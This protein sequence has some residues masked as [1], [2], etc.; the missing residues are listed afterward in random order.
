VSAD[1]VAQMQVNEVQRSKV[2]LRH[3]NEANRYAT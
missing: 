3:L 1:K 2:S